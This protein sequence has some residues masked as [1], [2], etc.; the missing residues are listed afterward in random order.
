M[1]T[2]RKFV[3]RDKTLPAAHFAPRGPEDMRARCTYSSRSY[4]IDIKS[5]T[6]RTADSRKRY[7]NN[8][9]LIYIAPACRMTSEA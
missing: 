8:N 3:P 1:Q 4:S 6:T 7:V 2:Q 5:P 9:T